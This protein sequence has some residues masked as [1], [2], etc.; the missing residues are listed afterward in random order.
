MDTLTQLVNKLK[1]F[2]EGTQLLQHRR[3]EMVHRLTRALTVL[4]L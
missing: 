1:T 2:E 3:G 4:A